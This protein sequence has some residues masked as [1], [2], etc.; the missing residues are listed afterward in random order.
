MGTYFAPSSLFT[1]A[2][3]V[4]HRGKVCIQSNPLK[5]YQNAKTSIATSKAQ[6]QYLSIITSEQFDKS[7]SC[8]FYICSLRES[9]NPLRAKDVYIYTS[10]MYFAFG[11]TNFILQ[12]KD[13]Y[14]R[15]KSVSHPAAGFTFSKDVYIRRQYMLLG[16][17]DVYIRLFCIVFLRA[18]VSRM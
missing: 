8:S 18:L 12:A 3:G 1:Q 14:I 16:A 5:R 6:P 2:L 13:V 7:C 4:I 10:W 9:I 11:R 17:N 15:L